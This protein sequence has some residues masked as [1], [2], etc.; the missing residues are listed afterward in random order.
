M[1]KTGNDNLQVRLKLSL[2]LLNSVNVCKMFHLQ[3]LCRL[4]YSVCVNS[5]MLTTPE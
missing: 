5:I 2:H 4:R 3:T 1:L